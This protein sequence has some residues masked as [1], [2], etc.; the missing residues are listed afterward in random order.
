MIWS[1]EHQTPL[2]WED[3]YTYTN[4]LTIGRKIGR[5]YDGTSLDGAEVI[6]GYA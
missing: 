1:I 4:I 6:A 2:L 3:L 5:L